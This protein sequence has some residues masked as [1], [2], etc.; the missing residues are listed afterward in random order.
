MKRAK[1]MVVMVVISLAQMAIAAPKSSIKN[2]IELASG[3]GYKVVFSDISADKDDVEEAKKNVTARW[4][5]KHP[6]VTVDKI[7]IL[8]PVGVTEPTVVFIFYAKKGG[9]SSL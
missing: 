9:A 3:T 7:D 8:V 4:K 5:Q 2:I 6:T 1:W